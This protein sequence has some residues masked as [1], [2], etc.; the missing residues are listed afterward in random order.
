M[1][2]ALRSLLLACGILL[3]APS[4]MAQ[5]T[6]TSGEGDSE[7]ESDDDVGEEVSEL[8]ESGDDQ[9]AGDHSTEEATAAATEAAAVL[10]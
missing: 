5:D 9:S 3:L 2:I 10:E 6:D 8:N 1:A 7:E 4:A